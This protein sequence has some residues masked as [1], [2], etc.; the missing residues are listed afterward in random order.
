MRPNHHVTLGWL[1]RL[2]SMSKQQQH[3]ME[4]CEIIT[5]LYRILT[6]LLINCSK[7]IDPLLPEACF[8]GKDPTADCRII[9]FEATNR[10]EAPLKARKQNV[11]PFVLPLII[12]RPLRA[13]RGN[14]IPFTVIPATVSQNSRSG[15]LN[16]EKTN[17]ILKLIWWE[18]LR[19]SKC[20]GRLKGWNE[21]EKAL[22]VSEEKLFRDTL[23]ILL[24]KVTATKRS[25]MPGT[26]LL[27]AVTF[28]SNSK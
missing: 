4:S 6:T 28:H 18:W 23:E 1:G 11:R 14:K 15:T 24:W 5:D 9:S 25:Y 2:S 8:G 20:Y 13:L 27:V 17:H 3:H 21:I 12:S 26:P 7:Y 22:W 16:Q 10:F 19:K